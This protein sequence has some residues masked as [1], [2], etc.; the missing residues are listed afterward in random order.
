MKRKLLIS[1][2][3]LIL[4]LGSVNVQRARSA[5]ST[6]VSVTCTDTQKTYTGAAIEICSASFTTTNDDGTTNSGLVASYILP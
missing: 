3:L 2:V 6:T 1:I 4:M 5:G